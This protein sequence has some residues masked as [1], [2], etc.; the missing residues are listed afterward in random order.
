MRKL[1]LWA[2]LAILAAMVPSEVQGQVMLGVLAGG[3]QHSPRIETQIGAELVDGQQGWQ[4]G[5]VAA[6]A[7]SSFQIEI[8]PKYIQKGFRTGV[9][10]LNGGYDLAY[11]SVPIY[12]AWHL[13]LGGPAA[14]RILAGGSLGYELSCDVEVTVG[15]GNPPT[16]QPCADGTTNKF[17]VG[18]IGGVGMAVAFLTID[19]TYDFGLVNVNGDS[20]G[21]SVK[22]R[23]WGVVVSARFPVG[24]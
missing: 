2:A 11:L 17:D 3:T 10:D 8:T 23:T 4:F 7:V 13:P 5:A 24:G 9:S 18:L 12:A 20:S 1:N 21:P 15:V 16:K 19:L 6:I 14:A 22:N